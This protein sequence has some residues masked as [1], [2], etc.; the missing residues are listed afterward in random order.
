MSTKGLL[1]RPAKRQFSGAKNGNHS[2]STN[3]GCFHLTRLSFHFGGDPEKISFSTKLSF[4]L[5]LLYLQVQLISKV[6]V[7]NLIYFNYHPNTLSQYNFNCS[8]FPKSQVNYN[9]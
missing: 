7:F 2:S 1:E 9:L 6:R 3:S 8:E 4:H 5:S